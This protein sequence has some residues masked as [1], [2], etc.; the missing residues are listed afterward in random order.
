[1]SNKTIFRICALTRELKDRSTMFR[2]VKINEDVVIDLNQNLQG[3]GCYLTK[4]KEVISLAKK[5]YILSKSLRCKV[6]LSLYDK[7]LELL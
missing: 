4:S 6:D 2:I 1:M 3:R 5:K 7:L